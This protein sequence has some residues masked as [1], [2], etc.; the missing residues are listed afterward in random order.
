MEVPGHFAGRPLQELAAGS[1]SDWPEEVFAQ[2][3]ESQVGRCVRTRRWKYSVRAPDSHF[4]C[5]RPGWNRAASDL[6]VEDFLYDLEA[7]S[8][9]RDNLVRDPTLAEVRAE[10]AARLKR[11]MVQAGESEPEIRTAT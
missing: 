5:E 3:S 11:R 4:D 8:H 10:L 7:D 2:I 9:E 1:A 6:Y